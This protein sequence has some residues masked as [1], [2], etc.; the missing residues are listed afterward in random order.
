[1]TQQ[2]PKISFTSIRSGEELAEQPEQLV[3]QPE[4]PEQLV[5]QPEPVPEP[6]QVEPQKKRQVVHVPSPVFEPEPEAPVFA[7]TGLMSPADPSFL[8]RNAQLLGLIAFLC[9]TFLMGMSTAYLIF[10]GDFAEQ[11]IAME[12][13]TSF[14][15]NTQAAEFGA[16]RIISLQGGDRL[17]DISLHSYG[18]PNADQQLFEATQDTLQSP[19]KIQVGQRLI[20]PS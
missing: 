14:A 3:T 18:T 15:L 17:A 6:E 1:M 10:S 9:F 11:P 8:R 19:D 2:N 20:I 13:T 7:A 16:Q 5:T 12:K 4:Q